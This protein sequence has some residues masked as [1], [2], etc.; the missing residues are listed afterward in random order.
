LS[1][2]TFHDALDRFAESLARDVLSRIDAQPE[3]QL[4]SPV[5]NLLETAGALLKQGVHSRTEARVKDLGARPDIGVEVAGLLTGHVELKAPGKGGRPERFKGTD[6][7]QWKKF[8]AL[9]NLIYTDGLEWCLYRSGER[10]RGPVRIVGDD[11]ISDG[12][13]ALQPGSVADLH[14]L[15]RDFLIWEPVAPS[16]PRG[17]AEALAP[18]CRLLRDD[19]LAAVS[20]EGSV[21]HQLAG[22]L[23]EALFPDAD[24]A[25]FADAYAQ[26]ITYALLLARFEGA[27]T[28][29]TSQAST[30]LDRR[31]GLLARTLQLLSG[32]EVRAEIGL[33]VDL[34][35]RFIGAIDTSGLARHGD[36]PWIYFYEDFLAAYD[37]RLRKDRGVY[38]T[39]REVIQAQCR[40]VTQLLEERFGKRLGFADDG[41]VTLDPAAGT[42]AYVRAA[43]AMG[44]DRVR[45]EF[46][47]GH[48]PARATVAAKN[49]HAF[50]IL[51]G[52]YAVAHLRV[53][54]GIRD[55]G[56]EL[57]DDGVHVYLTDTLES[58]LA[59]P[60]KDTQ[61]KLSYLHRPLADEHR[62]AQQ[63]KARTRVLVCLGNPPYDRQQI[64]LGEE[65]RERK[66]GWVR[67]GEGKES[68]E[69]P[70]LE[71]FLAPVREAG[72]GVHLKNLY[73]DYVYFWRWALWKVFETTAGPGIVSFITASSYLRGP[74][75]LG[76]RRVMRE[77]FDDL[78]ILDLEGDQLGARKTENIFA[79]RT[80]VAIAIGVRYGDP[81]PETPANVHYTKITGLRDEKLA[82]LAS[83]EGRADLSWEEC[84]SGWDKPFLPEGEGDFFSWPKLTDLFPWQHSGA[85]FKRSWPI[86]ET[87]RVLKDRWRMLVSRSATKRAAVFK[88]TRDRKADRTYTSITGKEPL[89]PVQK[90]PEDE[91]HPRIE[92]YGFRSLDRQVVL[93]DPRV[94]DFIRPDLWR[95]HSDHQLYL[96]SLLTN[97]LGAGPAAVVTNLLPD[98][99]HF[100]G[101]FGG[102]DVV[103]LWRDA[104]ATDPNVVAGLLDQLATTYGYPV[105]AEELF[106]YAYGI[107][108]SPSYVERFS[109]ELSEPPPRLPLTRNADLFRTTAALGRR[110]VFLHTYGEHFVP[111]G[112]ASGRVPRGRAR[113]TTPIPGT[114]E[115]YPDELSYDEE[116][117]TL[118]VGEGEIAPVEAE[119][120]EF[121]VS[122]LEVVR[123]WLSYRMKSG[124]GKKSSPLDD[125]RPGR[126]TADFTEELLKLL[127]ILEATAEIFPAL[128][129]NLESVIESDLFETSELPEPT[130][131]ERKPP[132]PDEDEPSQSEL[133]GS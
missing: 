110:L 61:Y 42:G 13:S 53:T 33:G 121:S 88:E 85:Q 46:G 129:E 78:W 44:L 120:W 117:K 86:G 41:V 102:K 14:D 119:V 93:A 62:R 36:D 99:H 11:E 104:A 118:H 35:E 80:P 1:D 59:A 73:N 107:L 95:I 57:P 87:A 108:A 8:Q 43:L 6:R 28:I 32:S 48:V 67:F 124:A 50:E 131:E 24:D 17:L 3:D 103:P 16:T 9:P 130:A 12:A 26:T 18:L 47:P 123:S 23:R 66:G 25:Q 113:S 76:M 100:R 70:I 114:P 72:E 105:E 5:R 4:K 51:V 84:Y 30:R 75:F 31:H 64:D 2:V 22:E 83:I 125:I 49:L 115:R 20:L 109:E 98:L 101:S 77:V 29:T 126:W 82:I 65:G 15:L 90:L 68:E 21:L 74:A 56:G 40:L 96:T 122:G 132:Q 71:D 111:D 10:E 92:R 106:A 81:K 79:I 55:H 116:T 97:P 89:I 127:W 52:P 45:E 7:E 19:V 34:L 27:D 39:P 60:S 112:E 54:Q 91:P 128:A 38:Y 37:P 58:P 69:M 63:V 133:F 94:G